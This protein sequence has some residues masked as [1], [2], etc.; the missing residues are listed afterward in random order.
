MWIM[1]L[2][3]QKK[4]RRKFLIF[5]GIIFLLLIIFSII[6]FKVSNLKLPTLEDKLSFGIGIITVVGVFILSILNRLK[7]LFK[8]K[9]IGFIITALILLLFSKFI[10]TLYL[11]LMLIS[12]PLLID[13][14][15]VNN[16]FKY[17]NATKY[18][19]KYKDVIKSGE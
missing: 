18:W 1:Y 3:Y 2:H 15:V 17:L 13:D 14:L 4:D 8:I 12:I 11:T 5:K 16:Y 10:D 7:T 9:S 6:S 19:D